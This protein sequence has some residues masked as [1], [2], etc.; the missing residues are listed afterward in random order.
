M[1][2]T[3]NEHP[4]LDAPGFEHPV[5]RRGFERACRAHGGRELADLVAFVK[6]HAAVPIQGAGCDVDPD[7]D[8][9]RWTVEGEGAR[10]GGQSV[11]SPAGDPFSWRVP[12]VDPHCSADC[13]P[14][15][16]GY[17]LILP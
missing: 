6:T 1:D 4:L 14:R 7:E 13:C 3:V 16:C 15:G 17:G 12:S 2:A 9:E 11:T 10:S 5:R 8:P